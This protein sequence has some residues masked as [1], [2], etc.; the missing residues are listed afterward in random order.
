[1]TTTCFV[2]KFCYI[3]KYINARLTSVYLLAATT[4]AARYFCKNRPSYSYTLPGK[5][6]VIYNS[7]LRCMLM[8]SVS[9]LQAVANELSNFNIQRFRLTAVR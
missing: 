3:Y 6:R 1:M 2:C 5:S 4:A 7:P 8:T 9:V